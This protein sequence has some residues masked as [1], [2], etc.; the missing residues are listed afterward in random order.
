MPDVREPTDEDEPEPVAAEPARAN[1]SRRGVLIG[2]GAAVA[3]ALLLGG[4]LWLAVPGDDDGESGTAQ[5]GSSVAA[6]PAT[7]SAQVTPPTSAATAG[8]P[9]T[10]T[11]PAAPAPPAASTSS[12][13][14]DSSVG[15][16]ATAETVPT[17]ASVV[18]SP[19]ATPQ[20]AVAPAPAEPAAFVIDY[21]ALLPADTDT[22]WERLTERFR[23]EIAQDREYYESFWGGVNRVEISDA[24]ATAEDGVEATVT[25]YFADG[26]VTTERTAYELVLV[27]D[28]W[29]IDY[30]TVLTSQ[31][32]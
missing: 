26:Q 19:P 13:T 20:P 25:Y 16:S 6:A 23:S 15:G 22:G 7:P 28:S 24:V 1:R 21:Y 12:P 29:N 2:I 10:T 31:D 30:S 14:A 17:T 27:G 18:D 3:V 11:Q 4:T 5:P 9:G 8:S 32:L